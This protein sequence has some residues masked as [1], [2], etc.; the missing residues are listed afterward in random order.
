MSPTPWW[1]NATIY[2]IYPASFQDSNGDGIG[3]LP[4]ILSQL[5]YIQS[6]GVDAI[7]VCP[8]YDSP[9]YDMGYDIRDYEAVYAP[10]GTVADV[11]ALIAGCHARGLRILLDLVINHTSHEHAWFQ[12]SRSS[13]TDPKRDWYIWRPPRYDPANGARSP[14]NNWRSFFGGSAWT[15]DPTT[16]EYYLHLFAEQQPDLNWENAAT[17]Q[18]LY[19]SAMEFWL[20]RGIDGFRVDTV[21]MYSKPADFPDA[22]VRDPA[23]RYQPAA[24]LFCNGP[25]MPEFLAEMTAIL[26]RHRPAGDAITVGE[27]PNTPHLP[28]V[29]Q[30]VGAAAH[31]LSM[32]FQFDVVDSNMG[33]DQRFDTVPRTWTLSDL[34]ARVGATQRLMDGSSDGWSTAFLE[35]HDQAR[36]VSRWGDADRYWAESAK[37]LAMLVASLSGTL[38]L[39]QGQEIGM[40]NAPPAWDVAEYKDVDSLNYYRY[41]R[42][43]AGEGDD[44]DPGALRRARAALDYLARDHARL[45]IQWNALPHAGFTDPRA[46]PWMRVHDNYPTVNVKRQALED[47]SVLNFWRALVRVRK[48]HPEVFARGVFRDTDP[49]NEAVFVFEKMGRSQKLVVALN[50]TGEVQSVALEG[51]FHGKARKTLVK[52]YKEEREDVLQPYEGRIYLVEV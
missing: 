52:N 46:T 15:F 28:D 48:Q 21:N 40:V 35:N 26:R 25:R 18:A 22:P 34:R 2:Q 12:A 41:V 44:D 49:Q 45:P 31:Q 27:L 38:F 20:Q 36:S 24:D 43:T 16:E 42:E 11:E 30:Y 3:D 33:T 29:L 13:R 50:F 37:M 14:P 23:N 47:G 39:Y 1:K 32:V 19:T 8:M 4:G 9:Q 51:Q 7:W 10:Y 17:R 6:L 5:D